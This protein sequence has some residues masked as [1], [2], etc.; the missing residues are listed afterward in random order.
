MS[1]HHFVREGQEPAL[2]ILEA[3]SFSLAGPLLEWVP[4]VLVHHNA[5]ENVLTWGIKV[6]ALITSP[7]LNDTDLLR[8]QGPVEIIITSDLNTKALHDGLAYLVHKKY[9][10]VTVMAT[11]KP[12]WYQV[13]SQFPQL[14]ISFVDETFRWIYVQ[15]AFE[16]WLPADSTL[17]LTPLQEKFSVRTEGL[18]EHQN[19][20]LTQRDGLVRVS[21]DEDFWVGEMI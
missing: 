20:W 12:M 21:A 5:L 2:L 15:H 19:Q 9:T 1:S 6:D 7:Q 18:V 16:K 14:S 4:L 3:F 17:L 10:A 8:D 11:F 13:A